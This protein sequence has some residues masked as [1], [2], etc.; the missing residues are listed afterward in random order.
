MKRL[1]LMGLGIISLSSLNVTCSC[2]DPQT[3]DRLQQI[4]RD[5]DTIKSK[6]CMNQTN[7]I[8]TDSLIEDISLQLSEVES[9]LC[10][11]IE[12]IDISTIDVTCSGIEEL[13][14]QLSEVESV[15]CSKIENINVS[16][17]DAACSGIEELAAQL[18]LVEQV[19]CSKIE[20]IDVTCSGIE[21]LSIQLS[22]VESVL[23]SK[24]ENIDISTIDVTC[25]GIEE[26]STQ[27]SIDDAMLCSKI[28]NLDDIGSC[29]DATIMLPQ[30]IDNLELSSIALLKTILLELRGC[31]SS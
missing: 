5:I 14:I 7:I 6:V 10:S 15:L 27:V 20:N 31:G 16:T 29:L 30:D 4:Q 9:I 3:I 23:C 12:N 19:L 24:I 28:G 21:E 11:K 18:S 22:E 17:I 2:P 8:T 25:S 13:S 1:L 26:L